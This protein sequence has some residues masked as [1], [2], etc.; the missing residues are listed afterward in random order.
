MKLK[1]ATLSLFCLGLLPH[2]IHAQV[3]PPEKCFGVIELGSK[4][5]KAIVVEDKGKDANKVFI[6]PATIEEFKPENKNAYDGDTAANVAAEVLKIT[7]K[8]KDKYHMPT[9]QIF[10]VM[11]SGIP[12]EVKVKIENKVAGIDVDR[13]DVATESRLVFQG[14]V[15]AHR[16]HKNEV[17]VLDIGSGNSKGSYLEEPRQ[18]R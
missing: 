7:S 14:I 4:G 10:V 11:S 18:L 1:I 17:V 12:N 2:L 15:P 5:I 6:P 3:P 16:L 8:M 13:I 9:E